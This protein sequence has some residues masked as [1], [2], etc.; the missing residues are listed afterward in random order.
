MNKKTSVVSLVE[1]GKNALA[2]APELPEIAK[3]LWHLA[4]VTP[5]SYTSMGQF[6]EDRVKRFAN[7]PFLKSN[8]EVWTYQEANREINRM[9]NGLLEMKVSQ[10]QTV[11]ILAENRP[12]VLFLVL[13]VAKI[14][15]VSALLNI[16]QRG[17]IQAHSLSLVKPVLL[18]LGQSGL[19]I[20]QELKEQHSEALRGVHVATIDDLPS[21]SLALDNFQARVRNQPDKYLQHTATI[22]AK[23]PL[24]YI[25]TSG[26]TG[27]PK[28][29]IM[30]HYRWLAAMNGMGSAVRLKADDV[31]YCCLPL[32]HNNALTVSLGVCLA[33]GACFAMDPKF[34]TS[35][36]WS[37]IRH[38]RATAFC[39]IGELLRYL[40]NAPAS[41]EDQNHEVRLITGNGL[42]P[43]IW[44]QFEERF[45]IH[46][47]FEFYGASESNLGFMNAF[48]LKETAGFSPI[49]FKIIE[50]DPDTEEP[51]RNKRGR[52]K[53]VGRGQV[54]LLISKV[55]RRRPF[56]GYTDTKA[57]EQKL[58]RGVFKKN[59]VWFN[60]GDLVRDQGWGHIQFV[61]RLGDTFRWK[62]ENVATSEVEAVISQLDWVDQVAVYG[63]HIPG[64]DGKAGMAAIRV[65]PGCQFDPDE[66]ARQV[67]GQLPSYAGPVFVRLIDKI[68]TTGTHKIQK[69]QLKKEGFDQSLFRDALYQLEQASGVPEYA[70]QPI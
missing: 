19:E 21:D 33:A 43:E 42:R 6:F 38:Y 49:P 28:A 45:G 14:G 44:Q 5:E 62:G 37:R 34:S 9:A 32:Y 20:Y 36:F 8:D 55:T 11:G 18:L 15:A 10:G 51:V 2:M 1:I 67:A 53:A 39:Y 60:S 41:I 26:T 30:S 4:T 61:D 23:D 29:S 64:A 40:L 47:I 7:Q 31:F 12:E 69:A 16:N 66:L 13:A 35:R 48:C 24:F 59:D 3:R 22:Q 63:V 17:Q 57:N 50:V 25:F 46:D 65:K 56:D 52:C 70:L 68:Q 54:G 58:L 27:F